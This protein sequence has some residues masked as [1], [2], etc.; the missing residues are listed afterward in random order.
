MSQSTP[1]LL[2]IFRSENQLRLMGQLFLHPDRE[3]TIAELEA[4]TAIAQQTV[5]RE[6]ER[7]VRAGLLVDRRQGRMHFVRPNR[8]SPYFPELAGLLLKALGPSSVLAGELKGMSGIEEAYLFGSWARRY[9]GEPG[10]PPGDI[11]LVVI[12]EPDVD[13]VYEACRVAG[14]I[15]GQGV[16]V[17]ILTPE[18]WRASRSGF[19]RQVR[20]GPLVPIGDS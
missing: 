13:D 4:A 17:V 12:G 14:G 6:V 15:L 20:S 11:D 5:S 19:V 7:L 10:Q 8:L 16:N 1:G 2:P 3:Q 9:H 18:E